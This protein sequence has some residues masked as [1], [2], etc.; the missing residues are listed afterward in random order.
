[1][2]L[3][4]AQHETIGHKPDNPTGTACV[5]PHGNSV[6]LR[7]KGLPPQD[8]LTATR[9]LLD[10]LARD[11]DIFGIVSELAPLQPR[12]NTFPGEVFLRPGCAST[13]HRK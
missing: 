7:A 11:A 8:A 13:R 1:M 12:N 9:S 10:G 2:A 5:K 3:A 4:R 6:I